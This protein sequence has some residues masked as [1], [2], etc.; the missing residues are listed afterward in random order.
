MQQIV[1]FLKDAR[2]KDDFEN[3]GS[4]SIKYQD[5]GAIPLQEMFRHQD[6]WLA[7]IQEVIERFRI[8]ERSQEERGVQ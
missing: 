3:P 2:I 5:R 8:V 1:L 7:A 4:W 6:A